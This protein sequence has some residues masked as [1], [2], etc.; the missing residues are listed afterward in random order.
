MFIKGI[1]RSNSRRN[2]TFTVK[3]LKHRCGNIK[4]R[5]NNIKSKHS[6]VKTETNITSKIIQIVTMSREAGVNDV[7][8]SGITCIPLNE[9]VR[10]MDELLK[11]NARQLQYI[12]ID[13]QIVVMEKHL[14]RDKMHLNRDGLNILANNLI[15]S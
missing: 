3:M 13:N 7:F 6:T 4:C 12:F 10:N 8:V 9:K 11:L 5:V 15:E 1:P 14:W 2:R